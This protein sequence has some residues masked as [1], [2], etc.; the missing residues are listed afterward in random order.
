MLFRNIFSSLSYG[1]LTGSSLRSKFFHRKEIVVRLLR[2]VVKAYV[3]TWRK[4]KKRHMYVRFY[5]SVREWMNHVIYVRI[6]VEKLRACEISFKKTLFLIIEFNIFL[7]DNITR[8]SYFNILTYIL[9][10]VFSNIIT[11]FLY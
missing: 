3:K 10:R 1:R 4:E 6:Y 8:F 7:N 2:D 9:K 5:V 11:S